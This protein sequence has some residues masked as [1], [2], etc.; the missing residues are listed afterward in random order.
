[1][2]VY[3]IQLNRFTYSELD[4]HNRIMIDKMMKQ[5]KPKSI[6]IKKAI[7]QQF[8]AFDNSKIIQQLNY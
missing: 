7:M 4:E 3:E 6:S 2:R 5:L 1:M 8:P